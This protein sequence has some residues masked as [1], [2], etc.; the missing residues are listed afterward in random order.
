[1]ER[2]LKM[3]LSTI[4]VVFSSALF[5]FTVFV[6]TVGFISYR[7]RKARTNPGDAGYYYE[8]VPETRIEY[9][10]ERT[11]MPDRSIPVELPESAPSSYYSAAT[12]GE[13]TR[14]ARFE[15]LNLNYSASPM[16]QLPIYYKP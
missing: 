10:A 7:F 8:P 14:S 11:T 4:I 1:M 13:R 16:R 6:L 12:T 15:V 5:F 3:A 2:L 9:T